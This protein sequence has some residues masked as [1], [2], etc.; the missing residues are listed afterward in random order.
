[1]SPQARS[2]WSVIALTTFSFLIIGFKVFENGGSQ[3]KKL[4]FEVTKERAVRYGESIESRL[5]TLL[6]EMRLMGNTMQIIGEKKVETDNIMLGLLD[7]TISHYS[8]IE[9]LWLVLLDSNNSDS[10]IYN[11]IFYDKETI[12]AKDPNKVNHEI[13]L[14]EMDWN[15]FF[16]KKRILSSS[17]SFVTLPKH[18]KKSKEK[19]AFAVH[20]VL[21][22]FDD[23]Q[24]IVGAVGTAIRL[25]FFQN[26]ISENDQ[27]D[28]RYMCIAAPNGQIVG[29]MDPK[30]IGQN[31]GIPPYLFASLRNDQKVSRI[32]ESENGDDSY[33]EM[34]FPIKIQ[35]MTEPWV[36]TT[37]VPLSTVLKS[38]I[39]SRNFTL[40]LVFLL[41]VI[42]TTSLGFM[43]TKWK[44]ELKQRKIV[45]EEYKKINELLRNI[46]DNSDH[47]MM[48][49]LDRDKRLLSWNNKF[50]KITEMLTGKRLQKG[51][52]LMDIYEEIREDNKHIFLD[53]YFDRCIRGED[54]VVVDQFK[55]Y[56]FEQFF[57]PFRNT[58]G[59]IIGVTSFL[60]DVTELKD[61]QKQ[62]EVHKNHLELLVEKRTKHIERQ[63]DAL[64][65]QSDK[66]RI[67]HDEIRERNHEIQSKNEAL[68]NSLQETE[69]TLL[70]LKEMQ[71]Q[72]VSS[73]KLASIGQL[74]AGIAHE[75]NNPIN[76]VAN[77]VMPLKDDIEDLTVAFKELTKHVEENVVEEIEEEYEISFVID[78]INDLL[79]GIE[80]G[81][82][83]TTQIVMDLKTFARM[84]SAHFV[85]AN[86][87]EGIDT[88]LGLLN[89]KLKN[90]VEVHKEYE[91]IPLVN[92]NESKVNQVF[93]NILNNAEQA[94]EG[95]GNLY[96]K[97][98]SK[99]DFVYIRIK[100][101]GKGMD[102]ETI[103]KIFD[104]FFTTK[105]VGL[106]TG[107]GMSISF[108][109]IQDHNGDIKVTSAV[110][111]GT[112][113]TISLPIKRSHNLEE[114]Q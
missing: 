68:S 48:Y 47:I 92:C 8:N 113:F 45:A 26:F 67:A 59:S 61:A 49:T 16:L 25:K 81:A 79:K 56:Y 104:P 37:R 14:E 84:D 41:W 101:D 80:E 33:Y 30:D 110:G 5:Q 28:N 105:P 1:M 62:L 63:N 43:S 34:L 39:Q 69:S 11:P 112:S 96:I 13:V 22:I 109:I 53:D 58:Q 9:Y 36:I 76:F 7:N 44:N 86:L 99:N 95:E 100:D 27:K 54:L 102:Q 93:M 60:V 50:M 15:N 19:N 91:G 29:S 46:L 75:I 85:E 6:S 40:A 94:I 3:S 64:R 23:N 55:G 83:R 77:N 89:N 66:L 65:T 12:D 31:D 17:E 24:K 38:S 97:T 42:I 20:V 70:K 32:V 87:E 2:I 82:N 74:T 108:G 111:K 114:V 51:D 103:N 71:D 4:A 72:L 78:E 90:R 18:I 106:G 52:Y 21:P 10:T 57:N 35:G 107:L 73:E 98:W 88:S